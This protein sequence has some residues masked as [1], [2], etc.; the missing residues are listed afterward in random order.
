MKRKEILVLGLPYLVFNLLLFLIYSINV[1]TLIG[2]QSYHFSYLQDKYGV[3]AFYLLNIIIYYT[4][5]FGF[6]FILI[7]GFYLYRLKIRKSIIFGIVGNI[8]Y[9][10]TVLHFIFIYIYNGELLLFLV[11]LLWLLTLIVNLIIHI[12]LRSGKKQLTFEAEMKIKKIVLD[13]GTK[14]T[15]LEVREISEKCGYD[16]DSII[17]VLNNMIIK[18]EIYAE[19]FKSSNTVS[20]DQQ[21]N[22][23]EIDVLMAAFKDWEDSHYTKKEI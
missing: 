20:F 23:E 7:S 5:P 18:K 22:I 13:L 2:F 11:T 10:L 9:G 12:L 16:S 15:R 19:F 14:F 17:G 21:A 8:E 4:Y 6:L 3:G 1:V